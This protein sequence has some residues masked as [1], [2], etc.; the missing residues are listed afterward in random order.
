MS[1]IVF[2]I[3]GVSF[4]II[5]ANDVTIEACGID[6]LRNEYGNLLLR[7][8]PQQKGIDYVADQIVKVKKR[9]HYPSARTN[10]G[11]NRF[12]YHYSR[13]ANCF[14]KSEGHLY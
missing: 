3:I 6:S 5:T 2:F 7:Q 4:F 13:F 11:T 10:R 12:M 8:W 1:K 9:S 14:V